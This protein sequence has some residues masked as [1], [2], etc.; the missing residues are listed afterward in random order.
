M[1]GLLNKVKDAVE[2][3]SHTRDS[4]TKGSLSGSFDNTSHTVSHGHGDP[5]TTTTGGANYPVGTTGNPALTGNT[6]NVGNPALTGNTGNV[7]N[8]ALTNHPGSSN[9]GPH[10]S[11]VANAADPRV[12]SDLS[13]RGLAGNTGNAGH[14]G[15]APG[16]TG[17]GYGS[18]VP[19]D[20]RNQNTVGPHD[21]DI[22]NKLDPRVDSDLDGSRTVGGNAGNTGPARTTGTSYT[23]PSGGYAGGAGTHTGQTGAHSGPTGAHAGP[24]G[25]SAGYNNSTNA[26]P[27]NSN[28]VNKAD[29]RVDSDLDNRGTHNAGYGNTAGHTGAGYG[30]TGG[31][32]GTHTGT[33]Y[34]NTG[35]TGTHTGTGYGN[36]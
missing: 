10:G 25:T 18:N 17:A 16:T 35:P 4:N 19:S 23:N 22:A 7:G 32:T 31:P 2:G 34:G 36:T 20:S 14:A 29:P 5:A 28:L 27:H 30:N 26:G 9:Y 13:N 15:Y 3:G 33:G 24:T 12:D 21:S 1:S 11:N 6:G 8:P